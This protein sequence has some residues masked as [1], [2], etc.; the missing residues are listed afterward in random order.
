MVCIFREGRVRH[1]LSTASIVLSF[2][3][4]AIVVAQEGP[5]SQ[6]VLAGEAKALGV[7]EAVSSTD[8]TSSGSDSVDADP[9]ASL[10]ATSSDVFYM[11]LFELFLVV[12]TVLFAGGMLYG[13]RTNSAIAE[14]AVASLK[15]LLLPQFAKLGIDSGEGGNGLYKDGVADMWYYAT[16]RLHTTGLTVQFK[17]QKRMD[18]FAT[19]VGLWEAVALDR[20]I[21][22]LPL[23]VDFPMEPISLFLV[24]RKELH[25][26]RDSGGMR[27]AAVRG[28][29][30]LAGVAVDNVEGLDGSW[31]LFTDHTEVLTRFLPPPV[32]K[33]VA[34]MSGVLQSLH[35]T[36]EGASWDPQAA[37]ATRFV[38]LEFDLPASAS[39]DDMDKVMAPMVAIAMSLVDAAATVK[40]TAPARAKAVELRHRVKT[41]EQKARMKKRQEEVEAEKLEKK[42]EEEQKIM[43]MSGSQQA[44]VEEKRRKKE[45]QKRLKKAAK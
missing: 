1:T 39:I 10:F 35:I 44:K 15:P 30:S 22:T 25:V 28:V 36:E 19:I 45:L 18:L 21:F 14:A 2:A 37:R 24:K 27:G 11:K 38:R 43:K 40:L 7:A 41:E 3:F 5:E 33:L 17:L 31:T 32:F 29:E 12:L 23:S 26:L 34:S 16:G 20:C 9:I 6:V 8:S 13:Y 42:R 4:L